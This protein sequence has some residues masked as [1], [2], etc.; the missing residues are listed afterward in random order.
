MVSEAE[1]TDLYR[2][3]VRVNVERQDLYL[4]RDSY[5][6]RVV[7]SVVTSRLRSGEGSYVHEFMNQDDFPLRLEN[8]PEE[9][10]TGFAQETLADN[11]IPGQQK[12]GWLAENFEWFQA[13]GAEYLMQ[14]GD[15]LHHAEAD[16]ARQR[17]IREVEAALSIQPYLKGIGPKQSRNFWQF[18][19][20]TQWETPLDSRILNWI[21]ELPDT[22]SEI[23]VEQSELGNE[24]TYRTVMSW[25]QA[26][27]QKAGLLP[28]Q[29]DA[30]IFISRQ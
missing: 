7:S 22:P 2:K 15:T 24:K 13:G 19:G 16:G 11:G 23:E 30:A 12:G 8:W 4:D 9:D 5:W 27:S 29:V 3:R 28:C 1:S 25:I 20:L 6:E 21:H 14:I 18:L 10:R 17:I 26:L